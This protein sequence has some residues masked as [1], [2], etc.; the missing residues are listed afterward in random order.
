MNYLRKNIE[1]YGSDIWWKWD[2][3]DLLPPQ[4]KDKADMLEKSK[5]VF[6]SWFESG[7]AWYAV[8]CK[9]LHEKKVPAST[10]EQATDFLSLPSGQMEIMEPE[11]EEDDNA[12]SSEVLLNP[13]AVRDSFPAD[14][15]VENFYQ[16]NGMVQSMCLLAGNIYFDE[17]KANVC[18]ANIKEYPPFSAFKNIVRVV[19]HKKI[20]DGGKTR[21]LLTE[22]TPI[23]EII[24][25]IETEPGTT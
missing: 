11:P 15:I 7:I 13:K 4:Y 2:I 22:K 3:V 12:S 25:G 6:D 9:R 19:D 16:D 18:L 23:N 17:V 8:L 21:L 1:K 14:L 10:S 5:L 24:T 20:S